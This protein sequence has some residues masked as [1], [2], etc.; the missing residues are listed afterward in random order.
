MSLTLQ[1]EHKDKILVFMQDKGLLKIPIEN[2]MSQTITS[3]GLDS[4]E[5]IDIAFDIETQL[6]LRLDLDNI[7]TETTLAELLNFFTEV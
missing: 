2:A 1:D 3:L 6:N 5:L 7:K 4:L